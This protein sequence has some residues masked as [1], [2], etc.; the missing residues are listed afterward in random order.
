MVV[1]LRR[2]TLAEQVAQHL[3]VEIESGRLSPGDTLPSEAQLAARYNVSRP[4]VREAL[5]TLAA[6]GI[7]EIVNGKGALVKAMNSDPI[8]DFFQRA[9][10][11]NRQTIIDLL[12]LR[13]GI[14]IQSATLAAQRRTP[15]DLAELE[16]ITAEMRANLHDPVAYSDLDLDLHL[17]IASASRNMMLYYLVESIRQQLHDT[18]LEGMRRR[19]SAEEYERV[20]VLHEELLEALRRGAALQ[21]GQ[22]MAQHFDEAIMHLPYEDQAAQVIA[23]RT[24][25]GD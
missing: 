9:V 5:K 24:P 12:E 21:A 25:P 8:R 11:L 3:L 6:R 7:I 20:Q 23:A 10:Q 15:E 1:T 14:E 18:I 22:A 4:I 2:E 16:R 19:N 13:R 17:R